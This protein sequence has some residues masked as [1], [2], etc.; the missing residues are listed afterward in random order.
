M[1]NIKN[2]VKNKVQKSNPNTDRKLVSS[3]LAH[4]HVVKVLKPSYLRSLSMRMQKLSSSSSSKPEPLSAGWFSVQDVKAKPTPVDSDVMAQVCG[5][6]EMARGALA[7]VYGKKPVPF[8]VP[9]SLTFTSAGSVLGVAHSILITNAPEWT[10]LAALFD[11]WRPEHGHYA[12]TAQYSAVA[13]LSGNACGL[14][15]G[16]DPM[17]GTIATTVREVCELGQHQLYR[18]VMDVGPTGTIVS[19][20]FRTKNPSGMIEFNYTLKGVDAS[21]YTAAGV[22]EVVN[23]WRPTKTTGATAN[24]SVG[25]IKSYAEVASPAAGVCLAGILYNYILLRSR[26]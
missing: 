5:E 7:S 10:S 22:I 9:Y 6:L 26:T 20:S 2:S 17:D 4:A 14:A 3:A 13:V 18:P 21:S 8:V 16:F 19:T 11:E 23:G 25:Y 15:L 1:S 12:F 24:N